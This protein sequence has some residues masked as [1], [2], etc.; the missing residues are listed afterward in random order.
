M[1]FVFPNH[2]GRGRKEVVFFK[3]PLIQKKEA[4]IA[5]CQPSMGDISGGGATRSVLC[6]KG[7]RKKEEGP[8]RPFVSGK[9]KRQRRSS[10][11]GGRRGGCCQKKVISFRGYKGRKKEGEKKGALYFLLLGGEKSTSLCVR[12]KR[13]PVLFGGGRG[14]SL[15]RKGK[16]GGGGVTYLL[17]QF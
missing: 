14:H 1:S 3:N 17:N 2:R 13:L 11:G 4:K 16:G 8:S 9:G 10:K 15:G 6:R 7:K 5:R 12:L